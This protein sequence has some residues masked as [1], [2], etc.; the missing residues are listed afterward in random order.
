VVEWHDDILFT[1]EGISGP[2]ALEV[3]RSAAEAMEQGPVGLHFDFFPAREF[4]DV[5]E[6]LNHTV[7]AQRGKMIASVLDMWLPD[8][9]VPHLLEVAHVD[10]AKRGHVLTRDERRALVRV[11]KS[12]NLGKVTRIDLARGEVTAG[13]VSLDEVDSRSMRS[14][15]MPGLYICGE[16]LD[17]AGPVGGYNLQAAFSTGVAAGKTAAGDWL[18]S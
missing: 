1:H 2:A 4:Q 18:A 15:K 8:R 13:G 16:V 5:D 17:I 7:L 9:I 3:S 14:R 12:W 10:P 6:E 11:L